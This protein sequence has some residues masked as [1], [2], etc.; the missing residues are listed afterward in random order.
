MGPNDADRMAKSVE[1]DQ[2]AQSD[3][4]LHCLH[5]PICS[6]TLERYGNL[7]SK[8]MHISCG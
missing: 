4:D 7:F 2:T 8:T 3:L 5:R 6:K 1:P